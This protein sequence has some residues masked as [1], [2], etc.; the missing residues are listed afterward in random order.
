[1]TNQDVFDAALQLIGEVPGGEDLGDYTARA[2]ALVCAACR[3]L[4][5]LDRLCRAAAGEEAQTLP[6]GGAYALGEEFPLC[7]A[8]LPAAAAHLAASLLFDE[9]PTLSDRCFA[10]FRTEVE[11]VLG[12][13]PASVENVV[14]RYFC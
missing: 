4:A 8:L 13:L 1:M 2:P 12:G 5:A 6:A 9:N 3:A 7:D 10:R 14:Q 11:G